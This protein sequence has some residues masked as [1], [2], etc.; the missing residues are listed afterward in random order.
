[1]APFILRLSRTISMTHDSH[2]AALPNDE[3][4]KRVAAHP[5]P[6]SRAPVV[7][8]EKL[9]P[10]VDLPRR[11]TE[12]AIGYDLKA[13]L[14]RSRVKLVSGTATARNPVLVTE[15]GP[16]PESDVPCIRLLPGVRASVPTGLRVA[17][18]EG[19]A[20]HIRP[21]AEW[22]LLSGLT[23]IGS[24]GTDGSEDREEIRIL[25]RNDTSV[26]VWIEHGERLATAAFV[27]VARLPVMEGLLAPGGPASAE[28]A[29][30]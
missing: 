6:R 4:P 28:D 17:V 14:L 19:Y 1:M 18:P 20:M 26:G 9:A 3:T 27:P 12:R 30:N 21:C 13:Y 24:S 15:R 8:F 16:D 23:I 11:A 2:R 29:S 10:D 7:L 22:V 5:R 25:V